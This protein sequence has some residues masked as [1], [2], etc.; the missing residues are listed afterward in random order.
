M[1]LET[2]IRK[3]CVKILGQEW[4]KDDT[5][6]LYTYRCDGLTLYNAPPMGV[7]F[8]VTVQELVSVV[9]LLHKHKI[10]FVARGAGT[11]LSGGAIP[12]DGSVIIEMARFKEVH[13]V[14]LPN[15]TITVG[16]GVI[17]LRITEH[18]QSEG[19]HYAPD[20]SSQKACTIGGN[21]AE[22]SGGPHTLKYGVT[23]NHI[24]G[25]EMVLP[26]GELVT[27]GGKHFGMPGPDLLGLVTGSEGTFGIITKIICRLTPSPENAVTL[28]GIYNSVR[29]ACE[30]VSS[31]ISQGIIPAAMEMIDKITI[32]A[33]EKAIKPGF[34]LDAEAV[35]IVELD[36]LV[37][38]LDAEAEVVEKLLKESGAITVNRARDEVERAK[39]WR[40]RKEAFGAIGQISPSYYVQDGVIPRSK[41]PE[42]LDEI[43]EIGKKHGLT[44]ANVF[45]A[46]DGNLH[47]LIL[48]DYENP[49]EIEK[50]HLIGEEI[51]SSCIRHGGTLSGEHGIGIEKAEWMAE[52]YPYNSLENMKN[53]RDFFNPENLLNPGKIFP[54]PGRCAE[55]KSGTSPI[56]KSALN[57]PKLVAAKSG[58]AV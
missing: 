4:V 24:V 19:F 5:V 23:V 7:V 49:E 3:E 36:G 33:V 31:I 34:P 15:R 16:P 41:L 29:D 20:P 45:H 28:L 43:A 26:D 30:S 11:G 9:K 57:K 39:I 27:L 50:A 42:V 6:T 44:V 8:P 52:L 2:D 32:S 56:H 55:S 40:A 14:D 25:I 35:L 48:Y 54:Q 17:N 10:S 22:N 12:Q 13:E 46:G 51:L 38:G 1:A 37:D 47:P 18:V 21:V 58:I 53:V